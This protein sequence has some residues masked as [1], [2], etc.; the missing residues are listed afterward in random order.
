M[1]DDE[2]EGGHEMIPAL[3][4]AQSMKPGPERDAAI[5]RVAAASRAKAADQRKRRGLSRADR[6]LLALSQQLAA[7]SDALAR[8]VEAVTA[9]DV[10]DDD[11]SEALEEARE[12]LATEEAREWLATEGRTG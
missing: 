4:Q 7:G 12:W 2:D 9:A 3:R 11:V 5:K 6:T 8:L 10:E 1:G